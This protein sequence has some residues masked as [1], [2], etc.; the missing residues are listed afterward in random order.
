MATDI[1]VGQHLNSHSDHFPLLLAGV[2]TGHIGDAWSAPT[3]RGW[4]HPEADTLD[5]VALS[6][7]RDAAYVCLG[8]S[9]A[10]LHVGCLSQ[11]KAH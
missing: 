7:L 9:Y 5:K 3:G 6:D 4:G 1:P 10:G 2:A 11:G 8:A